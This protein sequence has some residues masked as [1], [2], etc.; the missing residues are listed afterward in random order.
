MCFFNLEQLREAAARDRQSLPDLTDPFQLSD[1]QIIGDQE[2]DVRRHQGCPK[3]KGGCRNQDTSSIWTGYN[4]KDKSLAQHQ[5]RPVLQCLC[6]V[7]GLDL[8]TPC[9][10]R[11][12][13]RQLQDAVIGPRRQ[14]ELRHRR[15]HQA[16]PFI[17][18]LAELPN[19]RPSYRRYRQC[20]TIRL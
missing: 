13:A 9:Q 10:I 15:P 16:L 5:L 7:P 12:C 20:R 3:G 4:K 11:N 14:I 17:G 1:R 19:S 18:Q 6:Q 2:H 8:F